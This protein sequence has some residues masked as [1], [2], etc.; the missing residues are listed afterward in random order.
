M[1]AT[2]CYVHVHVHVGTG[3]ASYWLG[4]YMYNYAIHSTEG[5]R[6]PVVSPRD[7]LMHTPTCGLPSLCLLSSESKG[8]E[9]ASRLK[10]GGGGWLGPWNEERAK[11]TVIRQDSHRNGSV[12]LITCTETSILTR[13]S[14]RKSQR[15][16][17]KARWMTFGGGGAQSFQGGAN[18]PPP[19][20]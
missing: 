3:V 6:S 5:I 19:P 9:S 16:G 7:T 15:G 2:N 14:F 4:E 11:L 20:P 18:A 1:E 12:H 17:A 10:E 8:G 13:G